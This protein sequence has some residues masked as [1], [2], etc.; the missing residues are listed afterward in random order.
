M[1]DFVYVD[2]AA[3]TRLST[4]A[5]EAMMPFLTS[6]YANPSQPYSFSRES[7]KALRNAREIIAECINA[8]PCEIIFTSGGTESNNTII[9]YA[10]RKGWPVVT[11]A[12]EHH[13]VLKTAD[14]SP[15]HMI[16]GVDNYGRVSEQI[17]KDCLNEKSLVSIMMANN[18]IGTI[19]DIKLLCELT[20]ANGCVF[21]TDAVQALGHIP[22][23]VN[24]IEVDFLS[25]SA[26]KFN[27]PKGIG[28][29]YKQH[30]THLS[31]LILGGSQEYNLRAGTEN[32]ASI[33]GM[34]VALK[35]NVDNMDK[36]AKHIHLLENQFF[37]IL[38]NAKVRYIRNGINQIPGNI[39][40]SVPG[41]S[42][43]LLLHRMDLK[44]IMISTGSACDSDNTQISHVLK[45][46]ELDKLYAEGTIRISFGKDNT[47]EDAIKVASALISII[48][49]ST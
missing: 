15:Y 43:E 38:D 28:F 7:K 25:A 8:D 45:A 33:I 41:Q 12:I 20:H 22:I 6:D 3:T 27:G 30:N 48:Q 35:E 34:A 21:H 17:L 14:L 32:V 1:K 47:I 13:A 19:Q 29:L 39:S 18:E 44:G 10:I 11:S 46:I 37:E 4:T 9:S 24:N 2:N 36:N 40:L 26:H 23:N 42:G 49:P 31:P 16:I 5:L